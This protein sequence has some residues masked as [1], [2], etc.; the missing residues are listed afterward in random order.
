MFAI[1]LPPAVGDSI[2]TYACPTVILSLSPPAS[3]LSKQNTDFALFRLDLS[4]CFIESTLSLHISSLNRG[5]MCYCINGPVR[6]ARVSDW[7]SEELYSICIQEV[8]LH[9][10]IEM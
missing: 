9:S 7:L 10:V 8:Q 3:N 1:L 5:P 2:P 6:L 4:P